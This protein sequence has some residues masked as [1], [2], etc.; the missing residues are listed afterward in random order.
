M[1][2]IVVTGA[3][4]FVGRH[5]VSALCSALPDEDVVV[6]LSRQL[7]GPQEG[8]ARSHALD[9]TDRERVLAIIED[10]RPT[11]V[12]HLAALS[13]VKQ[14]ETERVRMWES[15]T[16]PL[17]NLLD[18]AQ[19]VG[20]C[21]AFLFVSSSEVYGRSFLAGVPLSEEAVPQPSNSYARSKLVG[22]SIVADVLSNTPVKSLV[23]RPFN[24]IGPGQDERFV[25]A[26][27][28]AQIA[29]IER[30]ADP[31]IRVGNLASARDFLDVRDV[32]DAYVATILH[33]DR[34]PSGAIYN[35]CSGRSR[36]ISEIL[37]QLL[38][39]SDTSITI[40]TDPDRLRPSEIAEAVGDGSLIRETLGWA[41]S[42][43]WDE[44]LRSIL[45][46]ARRRAGAHAGQRAPL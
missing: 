12:V 17:L 41:P 13:S 11:H 4:G 7:P 14:A 22:E 44:T 15:N 24:H 37:D 42:R 18:A 9:L 2:R 16:L 1:R 26:S 5:L 21:E 46:D 39:L 31:V 36:T 10:I 28:A 38:A 43:A 8:R 30:G 25:V 3:S 35:L 45:D 6:G 29:R 20:S 33:A 32:V 23:I 40:Q 27:F 19:R 34:M